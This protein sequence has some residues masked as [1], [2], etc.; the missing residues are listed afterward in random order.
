AADKAL[1]ADALAAA[2][3]AITP[4]ALDEDKIAEDEDEDDDDKQAEDEDPEAKEAE[5]EDEDE[6]DKKQAM[7]AASVRKLIADAEKRGAQRVAAIDQAKRDVAPLVGEVV[8][9]DSAEAI[10]R[11][12]LDS[13]GY[14][15]SATEKAPIATL[16]AMVSREVERKDAPL[17]QDRR[18]VATGGKLAAIVGPL[19]TMIRS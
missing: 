12:A 6:D 17:A 1:D 3:G 8:G 4:L 19:P 15:K 2:I 5:D 16:K 14:D 11:F 13:A 10:Y 9:M 7:D 18:A